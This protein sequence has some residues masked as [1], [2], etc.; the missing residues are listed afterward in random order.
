MLY[1]TGSEKL[2]QNK[3]VL[4]AITI[5][6]LN[7]ELKNSL[8]EFDIRIILSEILGIPIKYCEDILSAFE[9]KKEL[10]NFEFKDSEYTQK[11]ND[12]RNLVISLSNDERKISEQIL[13]IY[14]KLFNISGYNKKSNI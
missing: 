5:L 13:E 9:R 2:I 4:A 11:Y 12:F 7:T 6:K 10:I 8:S 14:N 3:L 1:L